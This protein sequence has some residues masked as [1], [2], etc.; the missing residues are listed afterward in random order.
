MCWSA[1]SRA[2]GARSGERGTLTRQ[3]SPGPAVASSPRARWGA[4]SQRLF[5]LRSTSCVSG[6][7]RCRAGR[8]ALEISSGRR[9][10]AIG[11]QEATPSSGATMSCRGST[12]H[13]GVASAHVSEVVR[14]HRANS[15]F[16]L[17][18]AQRHHPL[19]GSAVCWRRPRPPGD[20]ILT[21]SS[22]RSPRQGRWQRAA[23]HS[24]GRFKYPRSRIFVPAGPQRASDV[25]VC[26]RGHLLSGL[27]NPG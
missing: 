9:A 26:H 4:L 12:G 5:V 24:S 6:G 22:E 27:W 13:R 16:R 3:A 20:N 2:G 25:K 14:S 18:A 15:R 8:C 17:H 19:Y 1:C 21:S 10:T 7:D 11:E 23:A